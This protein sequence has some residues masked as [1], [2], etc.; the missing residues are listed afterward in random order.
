[1]PGPILRNQVVKFFGTPDVTDGTVNEPRER[2]EHGLRF[3]EKWT[4]R[5]PLRDPA[6]AIER[7]IY[8]RRYDYVGSVVRRPGDGGWERDDRLPAVFASGAAPAASH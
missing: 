6:G 5:H 2:H 1:M 7:V 3:N 4:Y 8:W